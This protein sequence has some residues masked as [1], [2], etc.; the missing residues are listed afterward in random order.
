MRLERVK[1]S[2]LSLNGLFITFFITKLLLSRFKSIYKI[3]KYPVN[4]IEYSFILFTSKNICISFDFYINFIQD[5][6]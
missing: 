6:N 3:S 1:K 4:Y 5:K 2:F